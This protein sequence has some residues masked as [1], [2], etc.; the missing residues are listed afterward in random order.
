MKLSQAIKRGREIAPE[1]THSTHKSFEFRPGKW[2]AKDPEDICG[3]CAIG[4]SFIGLEGNVEDGYNFYRSI[5]NCSSINIYHHAL[6]Q[7]DSGGDLE[8]LQKITGLQGAKS[9]EEVVITLNDMQKESLDTIV[10]F[11]EEAGY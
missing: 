6:L 9:V 10:E 11:L 7:F 4:F 8:K 3:A 2:Y 1:I 5:S